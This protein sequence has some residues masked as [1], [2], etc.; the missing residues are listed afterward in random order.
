[1]REHAEL[2]SA[3]ELNSVPDHTTLYRFL[4]RL[5]PAD[6][7]RVLNEIVRRMPGM[8]RSPATVAVDATRLAQA[9][10]STAISSVV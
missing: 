4:P 7:A 1:M 10:V 8:W 2:R 9:A 5:D 6:V 3:L